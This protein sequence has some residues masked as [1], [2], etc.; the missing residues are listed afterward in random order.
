MY[1]YLP[2]NTQKV[3]PRGARN[4]GKCMF[5]KNKFQGGMP[6]SIYNKPVQLKHFENTAN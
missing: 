5:D 3:G 2:Q 6:V 4:A 1:C